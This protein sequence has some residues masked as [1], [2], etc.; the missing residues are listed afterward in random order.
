MDNVYEIGRQ[1]RSAVEYIRNAD[2]SIFVTVPPEISEDWLEDLT[3][4]FGHEEYEVMLEA[5]DWL[6]QRNEGQGLPISS[7]DYALEDLPGPLG[8]RRISGR[9]LDSGLAPTPQY[10]DGTVSPVMALL[11]AKLVRGKKT[12]PIPDQPGHLVLV[13]LDRL[14]SSL[15][16]TPY[17]GALPP[18]A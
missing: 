1:A 12:T 17:E 5:W 7:A 14:A 18:A 11:D 2:G 3:E 10:L 4:E 9:L 6:V 16:L 8:A 15:I 13:R